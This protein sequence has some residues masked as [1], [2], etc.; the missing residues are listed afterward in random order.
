MVLDEA[1]IEKCRQAFSTFD[2][3]GS[4]TIDRFEMKQLLEA[5]GE[6]P[7]EEELFR[8]MNDI[9]EDGTGQIEFAEFLRAFEKQRTQAA[10]VQDEQDT[11]DAWVAL[12]G[13]VDKQGQIDTAKLVKIVKDDFGMTIDI[14]R[15][16]IELDVNK[17][18]KVDFQEFSALFN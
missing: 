7:T 11:L 5:I 6:S 18:G 2:A 16:V 17:D 15:L 3:D 8:F 10:E 9:D 12:G 4:G 14:Q 1:F 13:G